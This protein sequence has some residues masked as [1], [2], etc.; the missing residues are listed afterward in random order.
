MKE[1]CLCGQPLSRFNPGDQ[2]FCH[3]Y[4]EGY[5]CYVERDSAPARAHSV[6]LWEERVGEWFPENPNYWR[7]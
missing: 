3:T 7:A 2:C 1:C 4:S 5:Y 6:M